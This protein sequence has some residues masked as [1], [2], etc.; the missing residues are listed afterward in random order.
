MDEPTGSTGPHGPGCDCG[1]QTMIYV[2]MTPEHF[3]TIRDALEHMNQWGTEDERDRAHELLTLMPPNAQLAHDVMTFQQ[4]VDL[5]LG[6]DGED[7]G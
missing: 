2:S 1:R 5:L 4:V 6:E 7:D 3:M